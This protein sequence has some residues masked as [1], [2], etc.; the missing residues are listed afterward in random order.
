MLAALA[1]P[2]WAAPF[3]GPAVAP[4]APSGHGAGPAASTAVP[5]GNGRG[6]GVTTPAPGSRGVPGAGPGTAS[7]PGTPSMPGASTSVPGV[8]PGMHAATPAA[9]T[10][11]PGT[12]PG[13]VPGTFTVPGMPMVNTVPGRS[14]FVSSIPGVSTSI[15]ANTHLTPPTDGVPSGQ[16]FHVQPSLPNPTAPMTSSGSTNAAPGIPSLGL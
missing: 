10:A 7:F 13:P 15:P 4:S 8:A 6:P 12:I 3:G 11:I 2:A 16:G 1:V 5:G 14:G 9:M